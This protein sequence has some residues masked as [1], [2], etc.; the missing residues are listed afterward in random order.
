MKKGL[1][2]QLT[3]IR[4]VGCGPDDKGDVSLFSY[5]GI[6]P[7]PPHRE[8]FKNAPEGITYAPSRVDFRYEVLKTELAKSGARTEAKAERGSLQW[9]LS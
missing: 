9:E 3:G 5:W 7:P 8:I 2:K 4:H 6:R 1:R